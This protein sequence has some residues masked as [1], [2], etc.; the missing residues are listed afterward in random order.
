MLATGG[1][2]I[3]RT[4]RIVGDVDALPLV[5]HCAAGR[6]RTGVVAAMLLSLLGVADDHIATDYSLSR[7]G[8][9]RF[10][11]W[12]IATY[13]EAADAMTDQPSA[14][15]AAPAEAMHLFL[16]RLRAE[17]GSM[18]DYVAGLGVTDATL[19]AVKERLFS[20]LT[21]RPTWTTCRLTS[22]SQESAFS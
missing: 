18:H 5:F 1:D 17:F 15:L 8:M 12:V 3:A 14:F 19:D 4:L 2:A 20:R 11:E 10:K 7:L 13:P 9:A 6:T 16:E 21:S 22:C